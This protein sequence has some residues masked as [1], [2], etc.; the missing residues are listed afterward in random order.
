MLDWRTVSDIWAI[1]LGHSWMSASQFST[2]VIFVALG[3][4]ITDSDIGPN[5]LGI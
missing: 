3:N 5:A 2:Q 1:Y 4:R